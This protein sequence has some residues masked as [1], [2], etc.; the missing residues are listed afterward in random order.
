MTIAS[1]RQRLAAAEPAAGVPAAAE[2]AADGAG[3]DAAAEAALDARLV[4]LVDE[5]ASELPDEQPANVTTASTASGAMS[6]VGT[7][8][9]RIVGS[10]LFIESSRCEPGNDGQ[11][12]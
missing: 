5:P 3:E 10:F 1:S 6:S 12:R 7:R 9:R 4:A 8:E 11:C 2:P